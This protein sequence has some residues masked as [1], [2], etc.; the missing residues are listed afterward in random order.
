MDKRRRRVPILQRLGH[1]IQAMAGTWIPQSVEDLDREM[2]VGPGRWSTSGA[3]VSDSTVL[4]FS[5]VFCAVSHISSMLA[6][7]PLHVYR[8]IDDQRREQARDQPEYKI[9]HNRPNDEMTSATWRET[10]T[11]HALLQGNGYSQIVRSPSGLQELRPM[12]PM[13]TRVERQAGRLVYIYRYRDEDGGPEKEAVLPAEQVL[14]VPGLGFDGRRGY[15]VVSVARDSLG[16]GLSAQEYAA[17]WYSQGMRVGGFL[18]HPAQLSEQAH[19]NLSREMEQKSGVQNSHRWMVLEE[20]ME[21][22]PF[23][24]MS[25]EDAGFLTMMDGGVREVSRWFK[26]PPH[27]LYELTRSTNNNI[28]HQG[29]EYLQDA[30]MPW[31][32]RWEQ[33]LNWKLFDDGEEFYAEFN[34]AGALRADMETQAKA[35]EIER[36]NGVINADEWRALHNRNPIEDEGVGKVY[37]LPANMSN[38]KVQATQTELIEQPERT[39]EPSNKALPR[40]LTFELVEAAGE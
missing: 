34:L 33:A 15:S 38:A 10:I 39:P 18:Q 3:Y 30:I 27:K 28:E 20:G 12:N 26:I 40:Q 24:T 9:L 14:H 22:T 5:A 2:E 37:I 11:A 16:L 7:V 13:M 19:G 25:A 4:N 6:S 32:V 36:R 29:L 8:R 23:P 31:A 21:A 35:L 17:R 1:A